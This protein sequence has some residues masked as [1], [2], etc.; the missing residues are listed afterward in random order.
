MP[1]GPSKRLPKERHEELE[2][3][4][5]TTREVKIYRRAKV[6]LYRDLGYSTQ[7]IEEHTEYSEC[8]QRWWLRRYAQ[9]GLQGL[10][11]RPRSIRPRWPQPLLMP[12]SCQPMIKTPFFE[13]TA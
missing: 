1:R 9:E 11:D 12:T 6:I 3:I 2:R 13:T 5:Q 8:E 4:I 7:E 10:K